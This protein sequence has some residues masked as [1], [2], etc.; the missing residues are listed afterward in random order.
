MVLLSYLISLRQIRVIVVFPIELDP[1]IDSTSQRQRSFDCQIQTILIEHRQHPRK[2]HVY[3][4]S[5]CVCLLK[6]RA[7][8]T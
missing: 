4:V 6:L 8:G 2:G 3:E 5:F 7:L 1:W